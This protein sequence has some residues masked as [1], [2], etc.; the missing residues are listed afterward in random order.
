MTWVTRMTRVAS[1]T[2]ATWV[3]RVNRLTKVTVD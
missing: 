1:V 2:R 3:T